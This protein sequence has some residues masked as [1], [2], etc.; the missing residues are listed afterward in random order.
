MADCYRLGSDVSSEDHALEETKGFY[1]A[2][3]KADYARYIRSFK[4]SEAR[5]DRYIEGIEFDIETSAFSKSNILNTERTCA[6]FAKGEVPVVFA[7][8]KDFSRESLHVN[9]IPKDLPVSLCLYQEAYS[10][11]RIRLTWEMF[12]EDIHRWYKRASDGTSHLPGQALEPLILDGLPLLVSNEFFDTNNIRIASKHNKFVVC[13]LVD[14]AGDLP[15]E[16]MVLIPISTKGTVSR[17]VR[18]APQTLSELLEITKE[19]GVDL[20]IELSAFTW[21]IQELLESNIKAGP[22]S[23]EARRK[24]VTNEFNGFFN[25]IKVWAGGMPEKSAADFRK[26]HRQ[27]TNTTV[28]NKREAKE[29]MLSWI[30]MIWLRLPKRRVESDKIEWVEDVAFLIPQSLGYIC[31]NMGIYT[32]QDGHMIHE[33]ASGGTTVNNWSI[34]DDVGGIAVVK[35]IPALDVSMAQRLSGIKKNKRN[36][37]AVGA[38]A[39]GSQVVA[40][41]TRLGIGNWD[42]LDHDRLLPHNLGRHALFAEHAPLPKAAILSDELNLLMDDT[43]FSKPILCNVLEYGESIAH[44]DLIFDFSASTAAARHMAIC[45]ERP[46][47]ISAFMTRSGQY[48]ICLYEGEGKSVRFDDIEYQL[49]CECVSNKKL[50]SVLEVQ[51]EEE[52][53]YSGACSD[54]TTVLPQDRVGVHSGILASYIKQGMKEVEAQIVVW[55][56]TEDCVVRR[57]TIVPS[58]VMSW[59]VDGWDVRMSEVMIEKMMGCRR[60]KL[61]V[62]TGGVLIGGFDLFNKIVYVVD[63]IPSP[64]DS[65]EK[66]YSYIRGFEGLLKKIEEIKNISGRRLNYVGEWHTH[67][68]G[69]RPSR[70]DKLALDE[71]AAEMSLAGLPGIMVI[72]GGEG[73]H[74]ILLKE[75]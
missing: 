2:L 43:N 48:L 19:C 46:A 75:D 15:E 67:K 21:K 39:L 72:V 56:L 58:K 20:R 62:E 73:K 65:I 44:Y 10:E 7:L 32:K 49:A 28:A 17:C 53:R 33:E 8:R 68:G 55:E 4:W 66:P 52:I 18:Y 24:F 14:W 5:Y 47:I 71:Q 30:P 45:S 51:D 22:A 60:D 59:R 69:V 42:V 1:R 74:R 3:K 26:L 50:N 11:I 9:L 41:L 57:H 23:D 37:L 64:K 6:I 27:L 70:L 12:I 13:H 40:N 29:K 54:I 25:K 36:Y 34:R 31:E 38:G 61:P 63:I 35:P 16:A